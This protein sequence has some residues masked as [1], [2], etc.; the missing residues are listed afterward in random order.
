MIP[1][2]PDRQL[3]SNFR[4]FNVRLTPRA[5]PPT[6]HPIRPSWACGTCGVEWPCLTARE[7]LTAELTGTRLAM[8]MWTYLEQ[9]SFDQGAGPLTGAFDRFIAWTRR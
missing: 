1:G 3:L 4:G 6:H 9:F 5:E 7:R 8:L 2:D